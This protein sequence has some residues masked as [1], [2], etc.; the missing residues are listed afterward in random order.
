M[1]IAVASEHGLVS[2]HFGHCAGFALYTIGLKDVIL[3]KVVIAS[4]AH[5]RSYLPGYLARLG[6]THVIAGGMGHLARRL[7]A[8]LRIITIVGASGEVDEVVKAFLV[9]RLVVSENFC[10]NVLACSDESSSVSGGKKCSLKLIHC[11]SAK[12]P[13]RQKASSKMMLVRS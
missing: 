11:N 3:E 10:P 2:A 8:D 13:S 1:K 7:F 12:L 6:V 9:N 5:E 4:P